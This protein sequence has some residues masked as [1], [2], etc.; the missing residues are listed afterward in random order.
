MLR[1]VSHIQRGHEPV[2]I[3]IT[4]NDCLYGEVQTNLAFFGS[5]FP[6]KTFSDLMGIGYFLELQIVLKHLYFKIFE[7]LT[8]FWIFECLFKS[9]AMPY[10]LT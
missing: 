4:L 2:T 6:C 3:F 8:L 5:G 10:T 7:I 1:N 9:Q